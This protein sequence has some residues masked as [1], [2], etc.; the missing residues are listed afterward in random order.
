MSERRPNQWAAGRT[1]RSAILGIVTALGLGGIIASISFAEFGQ[2]SYIVPFNEPPIH[3]NSTPTQDPIA[4][5][6]RRVEKGELVLAYDEKHGYLPAL[7]QALDIPVSSQTLVYSKTSLQMD[8][9]TPRTPRAV[10][11]ND[12]VYIGY[13]PGAPLIEIA[14]VDPNQGT[15]FYAMRQQP[16]TTHLVRDDQ[17]LQCHAAPRTLGVPGLIVRS[18]QTDPTGLPIA[19]AKTFDIDHRSP[20]KERWGG[21]YVTGTH[22]KQR[23]MGNIVVGDQPPDLESGANIVDLSDRFD[24]SAYLTG[25]SDIV[26]LMVLEHQVYMHNLLTR[27]N[28]ETRMALRDRAVIN[29]MTGKP[30]DTPT[31]STQRR[32]QRAGEELLRYMLFVDEEILTDPIEGVSGFAQAFAARGPRDSKGRS[33]RDLDLNRWL[34]QNRCSYMIYSPAFDALPDP[35]RDYVYRRLWDILHGRDESGEFRM[36]TRNRQ[37]I[38]EILRETKQGLPDYWH[39]DE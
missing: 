4:Q 16:N 35:V 31:E 22:G 17:C 24:T 15:I 25:H 19:G 6:L 23:H 34:F 38:L 30:I 10:F 21:W 20:L 11:F 12:E 29:Q 8:Y 32:I 18:V 14:S 7:L 37:A 5:L 1:R 33:L 28:Y 26:A 39:E 3:Y 27:V 13:I 2:S 9:I 36:S